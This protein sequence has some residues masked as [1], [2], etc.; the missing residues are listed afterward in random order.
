MPTLTF[1]PL[2]ETHDT[3]SFRCG[4][5]F[6]DW[7]LAQE[8]LTLHQASISRTYVLLDEENASV[9]RS[10]R[11]IEGYLTLEAGLA[12]TSFFSL[13]PEDTLARLLQQG[14]GQHK[15]VSPLANLPVIYLAYLARD[16]RNRGKGYGELLLV[17]ALRRA[18]RVARQ[19]GAAGMYLVAAAEGVALY[20]GYGFRAYGDYERKMFLS[21]GEIRR[22]LS[23][24]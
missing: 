12:P 11:P 6:L 20:E 19:I 17:E 9:S 10:L 4:A 1:E 2:S 7:F 13:L 24:L 8:A 3:A 22:L 23:E 15:G 14:E 16:Q 21:M 18:E 5:T